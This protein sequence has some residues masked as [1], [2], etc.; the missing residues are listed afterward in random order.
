MILIRPAQLPATTSSAVTSLSP[1]GTLQA[2]AT[3]GPLTV[4]GALFGA[5]AGDQ[6]LAPAGLS[7][8]LELRG[9]EGSATFRVLLNGEAIAEKTLTDGGTLAW[10]RRGLAE[11]STHRVTV[12]WCRAGN[13]GELL[14][15]GAVVLSITAE[16]F[17]TDIKDPNDP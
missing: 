15:P 13:G 3:F 7:G 1:S 10:G 8:L 2:P 5:E 16:D 6:T 4:G 14:G 11:R 12:S 17:G 9:L